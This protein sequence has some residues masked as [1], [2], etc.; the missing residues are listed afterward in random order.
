MYTILT[1]SFFY[2]YAG[3]GEQVTFALNLTNVP[4]GV[5][6]SVALSSEGSSSNPLIKIPLTKVSTS[7]TFTVSTQA[8]LSAGFAATLSFSL[9]IETLGPIERLSGLEVSCQIY[10]ETSQSMYQ[11]DLDEYRADLGPTTLVKTLKEV[12]CVVG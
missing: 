12:A 10:A 6:L 4:G 7:P 1:S 2:Q 11:F 9:E 3:T 8:H 5:N